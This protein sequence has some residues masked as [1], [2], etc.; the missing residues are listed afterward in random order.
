MWKKY[1]WGLI[2]FRIEKFIKI[3]FD[4]MRNLFWFFFI[5]RIKIN[6]FNIVYLFIKYYKFLVMYNGKGLNV[7][8]VIKNNF[9]LKKKKYILY[10]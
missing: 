9:K 7:F 8:K 3:W 2:L 5:I 10:V 6:I 1:W 4:K